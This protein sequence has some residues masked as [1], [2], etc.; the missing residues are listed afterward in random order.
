MQFKMLELLQTL[1][2]KIFSGM[3][4]RTLSRRRGCGSCYERPPESF[5]LLDQAGRYRE[6][7]KLGATL[8]V[9]LKR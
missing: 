3:L 6:A 8:C 2:M 9:Q 5:S 7:W 4:K 1:T